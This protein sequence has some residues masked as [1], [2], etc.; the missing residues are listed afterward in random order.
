MDYNKLCLECFR[1]NKSG[2]AVCPFCG[3]D[4]KEYNR[5]AAEKMCLPA[6]TILQGKYLIGKMLG[7]GGFGITY[8]AFQLN[9]DRVVAIKEFFP[10]SIAVRGETAGSAGRNLSIRVSGA[11]SSELFEKTLSS[12]EKEGKNL[13]SINLPGVVGI[14]D[15]FRENFTA[16]LVM[17]YIS[18]QNL[19]KYQETKGGKLEEKEILELLEPV[20]RSM[21][22]IHELGIIHRDISPENLILNSEGKLILVDFGAARSMAGLQDSEGKSLTVVLKQGYA[23]LEQYNSRGVQGPWTD[24]YALCATI[25]RLLTGKTPEEVSIR[26]QNSND[27]EDTRR[28]LLKS[29][30]SRKTVD[31]VTA[32]MKI[33]YQ[34]RIQNMPELWKTLYGESAASEPETGRPN[35]RPDS[36]APA[37]VQNIK[38]DSKSENKNTKPLLLVVLLAGAIGAGS[39]LI[40]RNMEARKAAEK[41]EIERVAL[42]KAESERIESER[43]AREKA[44]S[45][46]ESEKIARQRAES[47][48]ERRAR[49]KAESESESERVIRERA[50]AEKDA[51]EKAESERVAK[52]KAESE[53]ASEKAGRDQVN[54]IDYDVETIVEQADE[55][56]HLRDFEKAFD[57]YQKAADSGNAYAM[58]SIGY[59]YECG[60]GAEQ[61]YVEARTWY[62]KAADS[63]NAV[64]MTSLG[65]LLEYSHDKEQDSEKAAEWYQRGAEAGDTGGM[66]CL[67]LMYSDAFALGSKYEE[68]VE[69]YRMAAGAGDARAM[70][71]LG[72]MYENGRGV[73]LDLKKAVEWYR[74]AAEAGN[75]RGMNNLGVMY[76]TGEGVEQDDEK[77]VEFYRKAAEAGDIFGMYNLGNCCL[78]GRGMTTDPKEALYWFTRYFEAEP[79]ANVSWINNRNKTVQE[80]LNSLGYEC[81]KVMGILNEKTRSAIR[82][83]RKDYNMEDSDV[84]NLEL[85]KK[86][87]NA[88]G[89]SNEKIELEVDSE[90]NDEVK[91]IELADN[92]YDNKE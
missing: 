45:E 35:S 70:T 52:K 68:A 28:T 69:W 88:A 62:N 38:K 10:S 12:F 79:G 14:Y 30:A 6:G 41:Q 78:Q 8:L 54:D 31:A 1:E 60:D 40:H 15:C 53:A 73:E 2:A 85:M 55:L 32:G 19:K 33:L 7:A 89:I 23:P 26:I 47:E 9:L 39:F 50:E 3:F 57:L 25:Y 71:N 59:M 13:A 86:L 46:A 44:E 36:A 58:Y 11:G 42:E 75:A 64:G 5:K 77:A 22:R 29:G 49:A 83:F 63:G 43:I 76:N 51:K 67:G 48:A 16:Y 74:K 87:L 34:D 80:V 17:E 92:L 18:G 90:K 20:I 37:A 21:A 27:E 66:I 91:M 84:I 61:N 4:E 24:V 56:Y 82:S 72:Y 65:H 81:G